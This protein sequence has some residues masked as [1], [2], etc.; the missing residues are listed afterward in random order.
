MAE[1]RLVSNKWEIIRVIGHGG[2]GSVYE[3]RH[4]TLEIRRA[5]KTLHR[6]LADDPDVVKRFLREGRNEARLE[7]PNIV[8]VYD[9]DTDPEFGAYLTM[10]LV[11][12]RDL[13]LHMQR[14]P[15]PL[16]EVLRIGAEVAAALDYAHSAVPPIVHR[17]IKPANILISDKTGTAK[18]T[19]FGIAKELA[20]RDTGVTGTQ[21]FIG[22]I[23]YA[24]PEQVRADAEIDGRVDLYSLGVVLYEMYSGKTF[25]EGEKPADIY[26]RTMVELE[27]QPPMVFPS[28]PPEEFAE[29][30]RWCL[31]RQRG[32]RIPS[33]RELLKCLRVCVDAGAEDAAPRPMPSG[34]E[35]SP[36]VPL[37]ALSEPLAET[38]VTA[39]TVVPLV[40]EDESTTIV[41]LRARITRFRHDLESEAASFGQLHAVAVELD[42]STTGVPAPDDLAEQIAALD[43]EVDAALD[44]R[45]R[46]ALAHLFS[47]CER[48]REEFVFAG[49]ELR[50][51][52]AT[53]I[54]EPVTSLRDAWQG[55]AEAAGT[56]V[57]PEARAAFD[58]LLAQAQA[59]AAKAEWQAGREALHQARA[60][61]QQTQA[62]LAQ[63]AEAAVGDLLQQAATAV[64]ELARYAAADAAPDVDVAAVQ[65]AAAADLA[66]GRP[67][68]AISRAQ[69]AVEQARRAVEHRRREAQ[70]LVAR[71]RAGADAALASLDPQRAE[72]VAPDDFHRA[73]AAVQSARGAEAQDQLIAAADHYREATELLERVA[74]RISAQQAGH[75]E[76]LRARVTDLLRQA[77]QSPEAVV[78]P[79]RTRADA[80]M[81]EQ[82]RGGGRA[83]IEA[84]ETARQLLEGALAEVPG[85]RAAE[86]AAAACAVAIEALDVE[87]AAAD[88]LAAARA[89]EAR[90]R[91]LHER[92]EWTAAASAF[93]SA[94]QAFADLQTRIQQRLAPEVAAATEALARSLAAARDAPAAIAGA[95]RQR[96][97]AALA[98]TGTAKASAAIATA[99]A[100]T[101]ALDQALVEA[102]EC[103]RATEQRSAAE[104]VRARVSQLGLG[105]RELRPI[106]RLAKD[107]ESA[108]EHREWTRA[109]E[110][111]AQLRTQ[112][113]SLER[114]AADNQR[115][116][117]ARAVAGE[118][119][120][121]LDVSTARECAADTVRDAE[122]AFAA[123]A[124]TEQAGNLTDAATRYEQARARYARAAELVQAEYA[125]RLDS[126]ASE[127]RGLLERAATAPAEVAGEARAQAEAVLTG[128]PPPEFAAAWSALHTVRTN[129]ARAV[130]EVPA[131]NAAREQRAAAEAAMERVRAL[132]PAPDRVAPA[133][134]TTQAAASALAERQW[135]RAAEA[136]RD[137]GEQLLALERTLQIDAQRARA[138]AARS[139]VEQV[140]AGLD[141]ALAEQCAAE[142]MRAAAAASGA[143][144]DAEEAAD[145]ERATALYA[146]ARAAYDTAAGLVQQ[147][148]ERRLTERTETLQRTLEAVAGAPLQVI[149]E[150][151]RRAHAALADARTTDPRAALVAIEEAQAALE[152]AQRDVPLF[153]AAQ[154]QQQRATEAQARVKALRR[155]PRRAHLKAAHALVKDAGAAAQRGD[156]TAM[157]DGYA[158]AA[159]AFAALERIAQEPPAP[160][161]PWTRLV[162]IA[163][164]MALVAGTVVW[165]VV[166]RTTPAPSPPAEQPAERQAEPKPPPAPA[167]QPW[168]IASAQPAG[169]VVTGRESE[170]LAFTIVPGGGKD[171]TSATVEWLLD[172]AAV[173]TGAAWTYTPGFD[174]A[175]EHTVL[176]KIDRGEAPEQ[177]RTW[178]VRVADVN[179]APVLSKVSPDP[180][181]PID[182]KVG[183]NV[184]LKADATDAD[185]G[186]RLSYRWS[187]DGKPSG[188]DAPQLTLQVASNHTVGL[189]VSDGKDDT[190]ATWQ[191]AA[192]APLVF[193]FSPKQLDTLR[194]KGAQEFNLVPPRG[195]SLADVSFTWTVDGRTVG[196]QPRFTFQASDG[197][198]VRGSPVRIAAA[199]TDKEGR[200]FAHDWKVSILPPAPEIQSTTPPTDKPIETES[201]QSVALQVA[202]APP[203]GNQQLTYLYSVDGRSAGRS[204]KPQFELRVADESE[205]RVTARV[206]DNYRQTSSQS[207]TWRVVSG[208]I[209]VQARKWVADFQQARRS[210]DAEQEGRLRDLSASEVARLKDAYSKQANLQVTFTA[211]QVEQL[212]ADRARATFGMTQAFAAPD[213][214]QI[215]ARLACEFTLTAAGG[216]LR[217]ER[218]PQG[219]CVPVQ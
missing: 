12:G 99:R 176:A 185:G 219:P 169:D 171:G 200:R 51:R 149:D 159:D 79:V 153:T 93:D 110:A 120:A 207:V 116:A 125:R 82:A 208:G 174:A 212:G 202:A 67:D 39:A 128:P 49:D 90:A 29:V 54:T 15:L 92:R 98:A 160:A 152:Q 146:E 199:A 43:A 124:R 72:G 77:G 184:V 30:V 111:Y 130:D 216:R 2:M 21:G 16:R 80:L 84:L 88:E 109:R 144:M 198:L 102:A 151:R 63:Q 9:F 217:E 91:E 103:Q 13:K 26:R 117:A 205:H 173:H 132:Q 70:D 58:S 35:E 203:V 196:E 61:F 127:L 142:P 100:A 20:D 179:R 17:D 10:E 59:G 47:R 209:L 214:R 168:R 19:D 143:A 201:G 193:D 81:R 6:H 28:P 165:Q 194:F 73:T 186:D 182:A 121:A 4:T 105:R 22:T 140:R 215:S 42:V 27:W 94:T 89:L 210:G 183:D 11:E 62:G 85:Y 45:D 170:P 135:A 157:R 83:A 31:Q 112:L 129:L 138:D 33:A 32:D 53:A 34:G 50:R 1:P 48:L 192:L 8:R 145:Y 154:E 155:H 65:Q 106:E 41:G 161:F 69:E 172:N 7:H 40:I 164:V 96:A 213:G 147:E 14:G 195:L 68:A 101:T 163:G 104:A 206:E 158:K 23:R 191:I 113:E 150:P 204:T 55:L 24:A 162:P 123:A 126:E 60:L 141:T 36:P 166:V 218:R 107:A 64:A 197:A 71:R 25:L 97:E 139:A 44:S 75:L 5:L 46:E 181:A 148:Y 211:P 133:E 108:F 37:A 87:G 78:G 115:L 118:A 178:K 66:A 189:T 52:L 175:G 167:A 86:T 136:Y 134:R 119:R 122:E 156:W 56:A 190:Q 137:A 38:S 18:V 188:T 177:R 95:A 114:Q 187:V 76:E 57:T 3:V 74:A 131:F 180:K